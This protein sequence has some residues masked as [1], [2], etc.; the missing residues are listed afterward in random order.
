MTHQKTTGKVFSFF[1]SF[2]PLYICLIPCFLPYW[3]P[4]FL[5]VCLVVNLFPLSVLI[6]LLT[7]LVPSLPL[8]LFFFPSLP[9]SVSLLP[10]HYFPISFIC[11][12]CRHFCIHILATA[13][14]SS[15]FFYPN[16]FSAIVSLFGWAVFLWFW[17]AC[18]CQ[19]SIE[20]YAQVFHFIF[21]GVD[22]PALS[23]QDSPIHSERTLVH[24]QPQ[25]PWRSTNEHSAQ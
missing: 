2:I 15:R 23:I 19:S 16:N 17:C 3:F 5:F 24:K 25:D 4:H 7:K 21:P 20:M 14:D 1:F 18:P 6:L 22:P 13:K 9:L 10:P 8:F 12:F 11:T